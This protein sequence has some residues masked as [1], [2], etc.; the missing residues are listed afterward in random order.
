MCWFRSPKRKRR[1]GGKKENGQSI[2]AGRAKCVRIAPELSDQGY[3]GIDG[4]FRVFRQERFP[5]VCDRTVFDGLD[6]VIVCESTRL[7]HA[8]GGASYWKPW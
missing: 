6:T 1:C 2:K 3:F 8:S 4:L 7:M 5:K